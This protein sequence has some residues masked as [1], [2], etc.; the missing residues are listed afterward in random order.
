M[1]ENIR[2]LVFW[3]GTRCTL[4][5]RDCGNLIPYLEGKL[6]DTKLILDNLKYI[7]D[8]VKIDVLQI[9]GGEPF[10]NADI[11]LI[12]EECALNRHIGK[13]EIAS[14]GTI[15]PSENTL[16]IIKKYEDKVKIRFS[17]YSCVK[18]RQYLIEKELYEQYDIKIEKY[19]FVYGT[20]M[21]FDLG[22]VDE[23]KEK[24][25]DIKTEIYNKCPNK[26]CWTLAENYLAG[27]GRMIS[28]LEIKNEKIKNN[29]IL[30]ITAL[31]HDGIP[32]VYHFQEFEDN[33]RNFVSDVCGYC[34]MNKELVPAAIQM[35]N[36]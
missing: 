14:N 25:S 22:S 31:R 7:T 34:R 4:K 36:K 24:N 9:Q 32:F 23:E 21:W 15:M 35:S 13:I 29:N 3:V 33:Y 1:K 17:D 2:F 16:R 27:C 28:Y 6:Y 5:C 30:D 11:G 8:T 19:E 20:G 12:V 10:T 18:E 26:S